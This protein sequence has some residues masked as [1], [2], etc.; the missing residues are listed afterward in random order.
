[1]LIFARKP[2]TSSSITVSSSTK[3]FC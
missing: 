3:T 2:T 1:M